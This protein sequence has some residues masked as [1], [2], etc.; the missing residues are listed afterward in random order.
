MKELSQKELVVALGREGAPEMMGPRM[1]QLCF[2]PDALLVP[3]LYHTL[4]ILDYEVTLGG[5][6]CP[7]F[8]LFLYLSLFLAAL[9]LCYC[10]GFLEVWRA[11]VPLCCLR[12]FLIAVASLVAE[13]RLQA[14]GLQWLQHVNSEV[15]AHKLWR[16][17]STVVAN[18]LSCF[19]ARSFQTRNGAHVLCLGRWSLPH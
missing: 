9:G 5:N 3:S 10:T 14:R 16:T 18:G 7:T 12:E 1:E 19:E 15:M 11:W 4:S 6:A 8:F 17:G 13:H 2:N